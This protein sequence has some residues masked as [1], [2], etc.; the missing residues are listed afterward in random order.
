MN[1]NTQDQAELNHFKTLSET[2]W[3]EEGPF[4]ILHAITPFRVAFIKE[5]VEFLKGLRI[6]DVGCGG[7]LLCE[8]LA[9]LGADVVGIDPVKEN[10]EVAQSHAKE[11]DLNITYLPYAIED[12]PSDFTSF[13]IIV[14]S[15][16]IE[17]VND[18][19]GF[20]KA[21][22]E[23]LSPQGCLVM[24]TFNKT[25]KSYLLGVLIAEHVLGWAPRGTHS[26]EK[27]IPP[28]DLTKQLLALGLEKQALTGLK[29]NP[30]ICDW[31]F[32][33]STDVNYFLWAGR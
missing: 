11:M 5:K 28:E 30:F 19:K 23:R 16:I 15:E 29:Y 6:L 14:A 4:R 27:F 1:L 31:E 21:C 25:L 20:L 2:W 13:D 3:D 8:P 17:H 22:V 9:R 12:L 26:W 33:P 10:I 18:P 7:G 32:S 24:T